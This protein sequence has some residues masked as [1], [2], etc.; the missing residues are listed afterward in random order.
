MDVAERAR[1]AY[2][3]GWV[4]SGGP[5]TERVKAGCRA[6]IELAIAEPSEEAFEATL[7]IGKLEGHWAAIFADREHLVEHWLPLIVAAFV[8]LMA[9]APIRAEIARLFSA[10][11]ADS[12]T[13]A[14]IAAMRIVQGAADPNSAEYQD[15]VDTLADAIADAQDA[16]A[17]AGNLVL[18]EEPESAPQASSPDRHTLGVA[19]L[20]A[21]LR[22]AST[23]VA[24][25][26]TKGL[27][28][29]VDAN[30]LGDQLKALLSDPRAAALL[31]DRAIVKAFMHGMIGAY[32]GGH[33]TLINWV[34]AGDDKVCAV[35]QGYENNSPYPPLLFPAEPH[36]NCRC[37]PEPA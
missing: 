15:A 14:A 7:Q 20:L 13:A 27:A 25:L 1:I 16:G 21:L 24:R 2:I 9:R 30:Q 34:T 12:K 33:V 32:V 8:K 23:D 19:A 36:P 29:G 5:M 31:G 4:E 28:Q 3:Q 26:L 35:C 17:D 22:G 6:A 11:H 18:G 10:D 37:V